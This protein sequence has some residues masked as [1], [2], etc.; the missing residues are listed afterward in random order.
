MKAFYPFQLSR[1]FSET[2]PNSWQANYLSLMLITQSL[3][4]QFVQSWSNVVCRVDQRMVISD[5]LINWVDHNQSA[6]D[7]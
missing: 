5:C 7:R 3:V 4:R 6:L 2:E 1:N